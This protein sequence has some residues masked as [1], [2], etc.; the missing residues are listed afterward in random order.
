MH[1]RLRFTLTEVLELADHAMVAGTHADPVDDEPAGPALLLFA[2]DGVYLLSNG[3]P[4]LP[5][6]A[7]QPATSGVRAV[8]AHGLGAGTPWL[9]Q[10]PALGGA[11]DLLAALPLQEP[12]DRR[13]ID[14]LRTAVR[15][16]NDTLTL[17]ITGGQLI[18]ITSGPT[19]R[20]RKGPGAGRN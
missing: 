5:P 15:L 13:L 19:T 7:G 2:D 10:V 8:F 3:R 16:G 4:Q 18:L 9:D 17:S 12:A 20:S 11:D 6:A 14:Q 1:A